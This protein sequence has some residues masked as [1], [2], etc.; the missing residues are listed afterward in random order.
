[1]GGL[2]DVAGQATHEVRSRALLLLGLVLETIGR[3]CRDVLGGVGRLLE[4]VARD[5]R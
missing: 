3:S 5:V 4:L 1:M 2:P